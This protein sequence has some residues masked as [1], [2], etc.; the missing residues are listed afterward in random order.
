MAFFAQNISQ[1]ARLDSIL[2]PLLAKD[3][4]RI[5][6]KSPRVEHSNLSAETAWIGHT[7]SGAG[8][9]RDSTSGDDDTRAQDSSDRRASCR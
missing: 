6:F 5:P 7:R 3:W 1:T 8:V 4:L 2:P 9:P